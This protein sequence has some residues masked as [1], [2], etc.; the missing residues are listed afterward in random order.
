MEN[1]LEINYEKNMQMLSEAIS[2]CEEELQHSDLI[3]ELSKENDIKKQLCIIE[4]KQ[5]N[6]QEEANLL[7]YNLTGKSG[8]I[9][10][11][12]SFKILDL[13]ENENYN[14]YFQTK[15]IIDVITKGITDINP[16][17]SRNMVEVVKFIK[18]SDYLINN[19]ISE[20]NNTISEM[21]DIKQNRSYELNKKNFNLYWNMEALIAL[22]NKITL[23]DEVINII[24]FIA[25]SNDYTVREKAAKFISFFDNK[26]IFSNLIQTLKN[27]ENIYVNK[28][29]E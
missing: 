12:C 24:N 3:N 22:S 13:I 16:M 17:V 8:P 21:E 29:F 2:Y 10:E 14:H 15:E 6:S 9:R 20:I 19:I 23:T 27:D 26:E 18:D 5:I 28:Y 25:K 11:V 1:Y 7:V 4:I